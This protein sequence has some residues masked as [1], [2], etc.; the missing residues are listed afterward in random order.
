[1]DGFLNLPVILQALV[2]T[3]FTWLI[4]ALG[5][6][7]ALFFNKIDKNVLNC[8][9]GFAAGVMVA[10]SFFSLLSPA[11]AL[12]E[13]MESLPWIAATSGFLTGGLFLKLT[14]VLLMKLKVSRHLN[15]SKRR[16]TLLILSIT[17]HNIPEGL[18]IGVAFGAVAAGITGATIVGAIMLA[19]GIG[20]QNFPEG[21]AV[22]VP[23]MHEGVP[24]GKAF[25]FGQLS[26]AVE[27]VAGVLGV[28]LVGLIRPV[29]PYALAFA[30]GA[31][32]YVVI[33]ALI[34]GGSDGHGHVDG[35]LTLGA[36]I[37]FAV[38]MGLDVALG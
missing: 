16:T 23:L 30:A 31:M 8:M 5:A 15:Q 4:T 2:A 36:M 32:I 11:I 3:C 37:G 10:A 6:L 25:F 9:L 18:A 27:P 19:I 17:V 28:L 22:A 7:P 34:P 33:D 24:K 13:E 29:L 20:I 14:D 12:S 21:T 35:K 38:M 26:G 1:M